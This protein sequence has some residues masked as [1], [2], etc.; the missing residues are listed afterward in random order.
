MVAIPNE[1]TPTQRIN[2][3][4]EMMKIA[5][6]TPDVNKRDYYIQTAFSL[7]DYRAFDEIA[8]DIN[9]INELAQT[10]QGLQ[11]EINRLVETGKQREN[12]Q[13]NAEIKVKLMT[14][15]VTIMEK[16]A[17]GR[18]DENDMAYLEKLK[19]LIKIPANGD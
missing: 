18:A 11:Q 10:V 9:K 3:A 12:A 8:E 6:S 4:I 13:I 5:Q 19:S 15:Y 2:M 14:Q 7:S 1:W 16:I 17:K